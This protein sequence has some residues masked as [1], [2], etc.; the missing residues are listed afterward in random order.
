MK[1]LNQDELLEIAKRH[2]LH[3][4]I[5]DVLK[6]MFRMDVWF[7]FSENET[8]IILINE[9]REHCDQLIYR[10]E[11]LIEPLECGISYGN[12]MGYPS[13]HYKVTTLNNYGGID[14]VRYYNNCKAVQ[15]RFIK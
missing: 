2:N 14:C 8:T 11:Y 5:I 3:E 1:N 6:L 13:L 12:G 9:P 15:H 7:G 4:G 10:L